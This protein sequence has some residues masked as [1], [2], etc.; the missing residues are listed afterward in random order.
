MDSQPTTPKGQLARKRERPPPLE[1]KKRE[2]DDEVPAHA[3]T[4]AKGIE[5]LSL[6]CTRK[7]LHRLD[8]DSP[9]SLWEK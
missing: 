5:A 2:S 3:E 9:T 4:M 7:A 6:E 8:N 1:P